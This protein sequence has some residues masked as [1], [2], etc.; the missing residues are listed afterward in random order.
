MRLEVAH[1]LAQRDGKIFLR[2]ILNIEPKCIFRT[3]MPMKLDFIFAIIDK[4]PESMKRSLV[5]RPFTPQPAAMVAKG[6]VMA[7][8]KKKRYPAVLS[9]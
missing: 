8:V 2:K 9:L 5:D 3:K 6:N 7:Q 1:P 4:V